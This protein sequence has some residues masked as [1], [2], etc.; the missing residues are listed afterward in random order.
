MGVYAAVEPYFRQSKRKGSSDCK[1]ES[2][3]K[4]LTTSDGWFGGYN[5]PSTHKISCGLVKT[6]L[7]GGW[8][9]QYLWQNGD[10]SVIVRR[11]V[12]MRCTIILALYQAT[13]Q[14]DNDVS[15]GKATPTED[16]ARAK[17]QMNA[18]AQVP[19]QVLIC[20]ILYKIYR[21]C[22]S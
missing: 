21:D 20:T 7:P 18:G 13:G 9:C 1:C 14:A 3:S 16:T 19:L 11:Y 4:N 10:A 12:L 15:N 6:W 17:D 5:V 22:R 8:T 2:I